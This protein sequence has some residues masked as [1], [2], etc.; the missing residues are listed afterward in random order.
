[1]KTPVTRVEVVTP[2]VPSSPRPTVMMAVPAM[3]KGR[4]LRPCDTICPAT[5]DALKRPTIMGSRRSPEFVGEA[6]C[7]SWK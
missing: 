1:M 4:Y 7:T 6:P 3:G 2:M 5:I